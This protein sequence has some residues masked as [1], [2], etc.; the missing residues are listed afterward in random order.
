[1][2]CAMY[3][4]IPCTLRSVCIVWRTLYLGAFGVYLGSE[5]TRF[6]FRLVLAHCVD[7]LESIYICF[8]FVHFNHICECNRWFGFFVFLFLPKQRSV[9]SLSRFGYFLNRIRRIRSTNDG[10]GSRR[11][12]RCIGLMWRDTNNPDLPGHICLSRCHF[13]LG[14]PS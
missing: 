8:L 3:T 9:Y 4:C 1:M 7:T 12:V 14:S 5:W 6:L 10:G 2:L 13:Y 11:E